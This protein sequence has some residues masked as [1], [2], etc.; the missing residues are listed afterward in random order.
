MKLIYVI[1]LTV[2][3]TQVYRS[4][5][6]I[7]FNCTTCFDDL[8]QPSSITNTVSQKR[9]NGTLSKNQYKKI[10]EYTVVL[11]GKYNEHLFDTAQRCD[12]IQGTIID[13]LTSMAILSPNTED[14]AETND[15]IL[16]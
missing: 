4:C 15:R 3:T 13:S 8:F 2:R 1:F 6:L 16:K 5:I 9:K 14:C 7:L 11:F 12:V 10:Y